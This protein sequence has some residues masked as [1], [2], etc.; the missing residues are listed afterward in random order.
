MG[1]IPR[2]KLIHGWSASQVKLRA[3]LRLW[4]ISRKIFPNRR[5]ALAA[6]SMLI[7]QRK[8]LHG[9]KKDQKLVRAGNKYFW[10]IYTPAFPSEQFDQLIERELKKAYHPDEASSSLQTLIL[11]ISSRCHYACEHCYEGNNLQEWEALTVADLAKVIRE[12]IELN[13]PHIQIGGGEPMLRSRDLTKLMELAKGKID[14][15]LS[16]SGYGFTLEKA[17]DLKVA[18]L[19][20]AAISLD[21]WDEDTHNRFRKHPEAFRWAIEAVENCKK[22]GIVPNLTLCVS[23]ELANEEQLMRYVNLAKN[24]GVPFVRLLEPRKVGNYQ[25]RDILLDKTQTKAVEDF[26]LKMNSSRHMRSYPIIQYPGYHQRKLGCYGGGNR[27]LF[28]DS[29]GNYHSCPFCRSDA[30]NI[31]EMSLAEAI[32]KIRELGCQAFKSNTDV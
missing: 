18:G 28:I 24:L 1:S 8:R 11:S 17:W 10:S 23:R 27:Y 32:P 16:T 7:N 30:G 2:T 31:K 20:G 12:A 19:T 22:C 29:L 4:K 25:D 13:I 9:N 3:G 5:E 15:W 26:F 14:F 6:F 21:H